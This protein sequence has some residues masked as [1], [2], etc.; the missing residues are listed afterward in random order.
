MPGLGASFGRGA[1][2][3][4]P[5]DLEHSDCILVMGSNMAEAHPVAFRWP[6]LARRHGA[7]IIHVDPRFSRTS[8]VADL[9]VTIRAGSDIAFLGALIHQVLTLDG[10]FREYVCAYTNASFVLDPRFQDTEEGAGLFSGFDPDKG[11]YDPTGATWQYEQRDGQPIRDP[12]LHH[13]RCVFQVLC[14]HFARYTAEAAAAIC[15]CTAEQITA[16]AELLI[17]NSGRERTSAICYAV[18]WTQH[19]TGV[20]II[21]AASILQ[22]LL[23]N[24]GRPGGGVMALRGHASIQGS[25]DLATLSDLLPGYLPQ[26][27]TAP[28]HASLNAWVDFEGRKTG[29]WSNV[30]SFMVSLLKAWYGDTAFA[31]NDFGYDRLPKL[32]G[33]Y[34]QLPCFQRMVD[35]CVRGLFLFGQNPAGGGP[36]ARLHRAGLRR[37]DWLV[38]RDWFETESAVF[39]RSDPTGPPPEEIG[40]EVFF[41][42]AAA[43]P[44]KEGSF[45]N[46]QRLIQ[47]HDRAIDPPADCRSDAWFVYQLGLRLRELYAGS[48]SP[49]AAPIRDLTWQYEPRTP[50]LLA[51]SE[52]SQTVGDPDLEAVLQEINGAGPGAPDGSAQPLA[53]AAELRDDGSTACGCW[54][55]TGVM[56]EAGHNRA[57]SRTTTGGR[58]QADWGFAWPANRRI[59]YNRASAD[60]AGRPWSERKRLIWWDQARGSWQGD[61]VPDFDAEK[62]PD[63]RPSGDAA[64]MQAIPGDGPFIMQP[65]GLACLFVTRGL[66]DGPLPVHYEP[67]ESPMPNPLYA[68]QVT[69]VVR[70]FEGPLNMLAS[71]PSAEYPIVGC[72]FRLTEHYL[73]GP[74]SRFNSW[75][76]ELQPAMFVE[77]GPELAAERG[78]E[79]GG[80]LTVSTVRASIEARALVTTRLQPLNLDGRTVHQIGV[81]F[82][83][84]F[85]GERV[86]SAANDLTSMV[87]EPNVSIHEGKVFACN[88][89][90]GRLAGQPRLPTKRWSRRRSQEGRH[91]SGSRPEGQFGG[92]DD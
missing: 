18:G 6:M 85:A 38:V 83:W 49:C 37:L 40:T 69:P 91:P 82:H 48:D 60:P 10:W 61:D 8:A 15:G 32:D 19:T 59:L 70:R 47:W 16:V 39:W 29:G 33:D 67:V 88:V 44:E 92:T 31:A 2:T 13:P 55:Y 24:I 66:K 4:F 23:G 17:A 51:N 84:G 52:I 56:P 42:P 25:T 9:H 28:K 57:R 87:L 77:L 64:G 43:I 41:L 35:G 73:S 79:N 75:L 53:S 89:R 45:T 80:W 74:M 78:I 76:N 36:N 81:P 68:Q 7:R 26:P 22:L 21:R 5:A 50:T 11:A 90:A 34:T 3:T 30:R 63:Y 27:T 58:A 12:S 65:D 20:Q 54:I 46:T 86:G 1:A 62:P 71:S 72:T 14:R